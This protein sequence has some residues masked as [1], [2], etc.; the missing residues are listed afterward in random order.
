MVKLKS[1]DGVIFDVDKKVAMKS[2]VLTRLIEDTGDDDTEIPLDNVSSNVLEKVLEYCE[3]HKADP[4]ED[5][6]K[7]IISTW[8]SKKS[9]LD[10]PTWYEPEFRQERWDYAEPMDWQSFLRQLFHRFAHSC[11]V[12]I[13]SYLLATII[14]LTSGSFLNASATSVSFTTNLTLPCL[15]GHEIFST[16]YQ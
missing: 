6:K 4:D 8:D 11:L 3:Y 12:L 5:A 10:K 1:S 2:V 15:F 13:L 16:C 9:E 7:E 14:P